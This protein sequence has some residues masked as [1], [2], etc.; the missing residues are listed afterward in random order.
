MAAG[1]PSTVASNVAG[2][3]IRN[4]FW[5]ARR[6]FSLAKTASYQCVVKPRNG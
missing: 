6:H 4:E 1:V 5:T 3:P 2:M